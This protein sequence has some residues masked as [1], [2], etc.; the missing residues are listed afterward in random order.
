V[1]YFLCNSR[2][3]K[4]RIKQ[5]YNRDAQI[6]YPPSIP[7]DEIKFNKNN[8]RKNFYF[9]ISRLIPYKRFDLAIEACNILKKDLIVAGQGT[10]EDKLK[11]MAGESVTFIGSVNDKEKKELYESCRAVFFP[12][13]EDFGI[14]PIE[15]MAY[16]APVIAY[17][18]GGTTESVID[19]ETG[20]LFRKQDIP[21]IIE[22]VEKLESLEFDQNKIK[23]NAQRFSNESFRSKINNLIEKI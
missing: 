1:D 4:Q 21:S 5:Y 22:A 18:K 23:K 3:T 19:G 9:A 13:E 20:V 11:K 12:A 15:A 16:G 2:F 7:K 14:V 8:K 17:G 10:Q 6:I